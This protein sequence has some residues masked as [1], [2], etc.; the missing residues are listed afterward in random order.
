MK[1]ASAR[2]RRGRVSNNGV[3]AGLL[4]ETDTGFRF[5]YDPSYLADLKAP[6]ISL[7]LP[8]RPAPFESAH[9]FPFFFGLLAEGSTKDLQCRLLKLDEDDHFGRLLATLR[10]DV[11]GSVS[12]APD[13]S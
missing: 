12:V 5:T 4:E 2:V 9:L 10:G 1:R 3:L 11:I 8:K 13:E 7:T 6:A